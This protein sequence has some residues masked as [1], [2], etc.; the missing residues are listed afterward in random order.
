MSSSGTAMEFSTV[1]PSVV[2]S[3]D[4]RIA[5]R[6]LLAVG[7]VTA[8]AA[9]AWLAVGR[10]QLMVRGRQQHGLWHAGRARLVLG[11]QEWRLLL[12]QRLRWPRGDALLH[13]AAAPAALSQQ[14]QVQR[15]GAHQHVVGQG[16]GH[17]GAMRVL[18]A[19]KNYYV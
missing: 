14:P 6:R 19:G 12:L 16:C 5:P 3:P 1:R 4:R 13:G 2:M 9:G 8:G 7:R 15:V 11:L 18:L 10:A 17:T